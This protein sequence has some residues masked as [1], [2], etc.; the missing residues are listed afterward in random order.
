MQMKRTW[1]PGL[2]CVCAWLCV[3]LSAVAAPQTTNSLVWNKA[4]D[5][6]DADVHALGL[7]QLLERIA[8]ET[9]WQIFVEPGTP[10]TASTK[11]K[12][13]PSGE[14]LRML[15]GD[16]N[17][18]LVPQTNTSPRLYVFRTGMANATQ[19]VRPAASKGKDSNAKRIPNELIVRLKPGV[20]I[21]DIARLLGA[22]VIGR[23]DGLNT[24]R[25]QFD[26]EAAADAAY[27][28]L[29]TN[30]DVVAVDYNYSLDP[31]DPIRLSTS[32]SALPLQ[33]QLNPPPDSGRIIVGL[34]DTA[35]QQLCGDL[36]S[37][38]LKPISVA[39]DAQP[40]GDSPTHATAMAETI[41]RGVLAATK[42]TSVQ[43]QPVDVYGPNATTTAFDVG[44]GIV[45][46][47]NSGANII[48]LSLGGQGDSQ[49]LQSLIQAVH[50]RGIPIFAAAGNQPVTTPFYPAA[51][52]GVIAVTA[53]EQGQFA[54]YANRG[55]FVAAGAPGSEVFCYSGQSY[56]ET[57]TSTSSAYTSG[58]AA[59]LADMT[60]TSPSDV[61]PI[62]ESRLPVP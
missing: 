11:F 20:K 7:Q 28:Q 60:K 52:P 2:T 45:Q 37:F 51:D 23:I 54:P 58:M 44:S 49:F 48:N 42:S 32:G 33:L 46:A 15:L 16:L 59:G 57:G 34:I 29:A 56:I 13:L 27:T 10:Y 61:V 62:V 55:S 25:L 30:N 31:P 21:E 1:L 36:N 40:A 18:A 47:V 26:N 4:K 22:K 35:Y 8:T 19:L 53:V 24:Y 41:L 39:G 14:A 5:R 50:N 17:F 43:I 12:S 38:V 9:G 6:V 3:C